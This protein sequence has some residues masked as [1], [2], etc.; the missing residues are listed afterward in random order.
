MYEEEGGSGPDLLVMLHGLGA[1]G[2]VWSPMCAAAG[3]HWRGRWLVLDLP[4]HGQSEPQHSY[5]LGQCAATVAQ[6]LLPRIDPAGRLVVLGH[7]FGGVIGL[8]LASGWFGVT[9]DRVFGAGIK[10]S[11][12]DEE[13]RR[14]DTLAA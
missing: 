7:S 2:A 10:V 5:A 9:P 4:G 13:L 3:R 6:A 12:T 1:T 8:A 14:L 11:W